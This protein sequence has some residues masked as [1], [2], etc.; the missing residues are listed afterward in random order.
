MRHPFLTRGAF[1]IKQSSGFANTNFNRL[2]CYD[3]QNSVPHIAFGIP[4]GFSEK[5]IV[6][7]SAFPQPRFKSVG[8]IGD[9]VFGDCIQQT[10]VEEMAKSR[11]VLALEGN[12]GLK[13][14]ECLDCSLEADCSRFDAVFSCRLSRDRTDE[15]VGQDMRPEFLPDKCWCL[16]SQD[17]HL[18]RLFQ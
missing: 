4:P 9:S 7:G 3:Y 12:H 2:T 14:F 8:P 5:A 11:V 17:V 6:F 13:G 16:A 15:I 18:Q 1:V 10:M